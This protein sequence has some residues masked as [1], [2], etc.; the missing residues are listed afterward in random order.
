MNNTRP[1]WRRR[2][3]PVKY[4]IAL[5]RPETLAKGER[6]E[7][8]QDARRESARSETSLRSAQ[9]GSN[10]LADTLSDCRN[11]HYHCEQPFCPICARD[12]RRWLIG[13]LLRITRGNTRVH[14][15]TVLLQEAAADN[16][17]ELDPAPYRHSLRKRLQRSGLDVPVIGGFEV[18]YKAKRKVWVLHINLVVVGGDKEAHKKFRKGFDG[19]DLDR[20]LISAK[21]TDPAQ[22]LSYVLKFSTYHRPYEQQGP[23]KSPAKS[24]NGRQHAALV[25][26]MSRFE[27]KD[28]LFLVNARRS[29]HVISI[30]SETI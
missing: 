26:W 19:S 2:K 12:F 9:R 5:L 22:Q 28:L 18:V 29:G 23:A 8:P 30:R 1:F 16:I 20:P 21:L 25:K 24:L 4:D 11:G 27:F 14:I 17:S 3:P 13:Q 10:A 7:T 15:Y 6:F